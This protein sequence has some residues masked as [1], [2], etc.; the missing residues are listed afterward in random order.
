MMT[1][2]DDV[3]ARLTQDQLD[4]YRENGWLLVNDLLPCSIDELRVAVEAVA[5]KDELMQHYE[6]TDDGP[7]LARSEYFIDASPVLDQVLRRSA[8]SDI[9]GELLGESGF[10]YNCLLYTSDAADE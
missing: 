3:M 6:M 5:A 7:R 8:I 1:S 10:L 9:A 2:Y 4:F